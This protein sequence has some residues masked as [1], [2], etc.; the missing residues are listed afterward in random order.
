MGN[1]K[2]PIIPVFKAG[3]PRTREPNAGSLMTPLLTT[4]D[5]GQWLKL[6]EP[7]I[8]KKVCYNRIPFVRIGRAIRFRPEEIEVWLRAQNV[9]M[10]G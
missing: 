2:I 8:R 1:P 5:L 4:A 3:V 9:S 6:K 7:T 10:K